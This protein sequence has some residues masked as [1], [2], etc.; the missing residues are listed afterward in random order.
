MKRGK[1]ETMDVEKTVEFLLEQQAVSA[2]RMG[3][4]HTIVHEMALNQVALGKAQA[5]FDAN[6]QQIQG[7]MQGIQGTMQGFQ[8]NM[9]ELQ[10]QQKQTGET[11]Q[12]LGVRVDRLVQALEN[13][14]GSNGSAP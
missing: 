6:M 9:R 3:E 1:I 10:A 12:Q 8:G 11:V 7:T 2:A 13:R 14:F 4:L 5:R